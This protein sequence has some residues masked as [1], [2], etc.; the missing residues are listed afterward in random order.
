MSRPSRL[1]HQAAQTFE[2]IP[3]QASGSIEPPVW[4]VLPMLYWSRCQ[5]AWLEAVEPYLSFPR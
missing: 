1:G 2:S 5:L 4:M 3:Q